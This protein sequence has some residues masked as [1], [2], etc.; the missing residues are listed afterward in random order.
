MLKAPACLLRCYLTQARAKR[1]IMSRVIPIAVL[2]DH[3]WSPAAPACIWST[4]APACTWSSSQ[5]QSGSG[6]LPPHC[7][8]FDLQSSRARLHPDPGAFPP[9][10]R[11]AIWSSA[12]T[13]CT[14]PSSSSRSCS[15]RRTSSSSRRTARSRGRRRPPPLCTASLCW[16]TQSNSS[17]PWHRRKTLH[18]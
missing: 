7:R 10:C 13:A 18:W 16:A 8:R 3:S 4:V 15:R 9:L 17:R 2:R 6:A 11:H 14:S 1:S 5:N 12:A